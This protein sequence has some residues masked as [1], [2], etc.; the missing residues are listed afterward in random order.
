MCSE[1]IMFKSIHNPNNN[2]NFLDMR[3]FI[4]AKTRHVSLVSCHLPN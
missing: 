1:N 3:H 4:H 2:L